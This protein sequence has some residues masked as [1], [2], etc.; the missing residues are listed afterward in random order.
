MSLSD[1]TEAVRRKIGEN[2]GLAATLKF[3]LA[4]DGVIHVDADSVPNV[5]SNDDKPAD[6]TI[7]LSKADLAAMLAGDLDP[8]SAFMMGKIAVEGDMSV[9]MKLSQVV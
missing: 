1:V 3:D 6:C 5:V 8:T 9:A 2:S 4:D 7:A